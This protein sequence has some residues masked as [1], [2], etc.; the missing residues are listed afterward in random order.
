MKI[1][2][3]TKEMYLFDKLN[4]LNH[5]NSIELDIK[6]TNKKAFIKMMKNVNNKSNNLDISV[7]GDKYIINKRNSLLK[8]AI[9]KK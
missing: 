1:R 5:F 7:K 8:L 4:L 3:I 6:K 9:Y 2:L